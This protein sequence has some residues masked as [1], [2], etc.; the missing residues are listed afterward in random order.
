M[1]LYI[2]PDKKKAMLVRRELNANWL[3]I[4]EDQ[5][6]SRICGRSFGEIVLDDDIDPEKYPLLGSY[7]SGP[8]GQV[9]RLTTRDGSTIG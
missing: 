5:I 2:A 3:V 8:Q 6:E 1:N 9:G 4:H 7:T